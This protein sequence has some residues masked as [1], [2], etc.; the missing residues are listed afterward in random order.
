M[1]ETE[2]LEEFSPEDLNRRLEG[3]SIQFFKGLKEDSREI[4]GKRYKSVLH[5]SKTQN[6]VEI[7][8]SKAYCHRCNVMFRR[9]WEDPDYRYEKADCSQY[10][11]TTDR[12]GVKIERYL[13][14]L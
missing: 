10:V 3:Y 13:P 5:G 2:E 4:K 8:D 7:D 1:G 6:T 9:E 14:S 12:K 11:V